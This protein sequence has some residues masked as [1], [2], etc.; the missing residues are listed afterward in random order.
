MILVIATKNTGKLSEFKLLFKNNTVNIYGINDLET[1]T[2]VKYLE[3]NENSS[4]FLSNGFCKLISLSNYVKSTSVFKSEKDSNIKILSDDSGLCL[5][6]L[7]ME[8]G[9]NSA[10]FAGIPR[11]DLKNNMKLVH[12][13]KNNAASFLLNGEKR[14]VGFFT[15]FLMLCDLNSLPY[16]PKQKALFDG[17]KFTNPKIMDYERDLLGKIDLSVQAHSLFKIIKASFFSEDFKNEK[18][19]IRL[20]VGVCVGHVSE[21]DREVIGRGHGYDPYFFPLT[22]PFESFSTFKIEEKNE[23]SHRGLAAKNLLNELG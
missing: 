2:G 9:V 8:P 19:F 23:L 21:K 11:N 1:L 12:E 7:N 3:P 16:L 14:L 13:I 5:P 6:A 18:D 10:Y 20:S 17:K 22:K 15:C 4:L